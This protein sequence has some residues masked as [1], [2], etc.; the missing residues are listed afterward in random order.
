M[1]GNWS[2]GEYFKDK[3]CRMAWDLLTNVYKIDSSRLYVT[4]FG[5]D[6]KQGLQPDLECKEIWR[7]IGVP[8]DRILPYGMSENFWEMGATGPCGTCTEI[9]IDHL[10]N[11]DPMQRAQYVNAG[12]PDLTELWNV[13]FIEYNRLVVLLSIG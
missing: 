10:P 2:F 3:A 9:H 5:G 4:Y 13:V 6:A 12:L 8:S 11:S 7:S 1:L